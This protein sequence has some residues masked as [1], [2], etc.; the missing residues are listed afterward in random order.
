MAGSQTR[1]L[2]RM[3]DREA[4]KLYQRITKETMEQINK[5]PEE[6]RQKLLDLYKLMMEQ[7]EEVKKEKQDGM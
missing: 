6:E 1:R 2:K 5:Q 3:R 7:K 4:Q